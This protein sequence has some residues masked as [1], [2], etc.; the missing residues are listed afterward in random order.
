MSKSERGINPSVP[1]S[2]TGCVECEAARSWWFHLRRCAQCGHIGCCDQSLGK[3]AT[4]HFNET[5]HPVIASFE[6]GE[7][8]FYDY[9]TETFLEGPAL[10]PPRWHPD[11]QP[12]PGPRGRVPA[13]WQSELN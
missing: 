7:E 5:G 8:W 11:H 6:A 10:A 12:V 3:H 4:T 13:D 2:G 1:P 9:T